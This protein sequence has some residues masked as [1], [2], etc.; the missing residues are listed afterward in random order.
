MHLSPYANCYRCPWKLQYPSCGLACAEHLRN[1]M[2]NDT[3]GE[4]AAIILEPMQGTAGNVI[5]PDEVVYAVRENA[6]EFD[7]LLIAGEILTGFGHAGP[8]C[9]SQQFHLPPP[10]LTIVP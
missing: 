3:Q 9:A 6:D 2:K 10:L 8:L 7:A 1:V 5:P 4:V